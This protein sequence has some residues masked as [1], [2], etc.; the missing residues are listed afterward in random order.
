MFSTFYSL[1][2]LIQ[3]KIQMFLLIQARK[4]NTQGSIA[5]VVDDT[6]HFL[7]FA[8]WGNGNVINLIRYQLIFNPDVTNMLW[9]QL[10]QIYALLLPK[11][12]FIAAY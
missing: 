6:L 7:Q 1:V 3:P 11:H 2:E 8:I 4:M 12:A 9:C 10:V 5:K